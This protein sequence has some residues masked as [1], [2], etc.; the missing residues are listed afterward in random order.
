MVNKLIIR[1]DRP[2]G[3]IN[4][5]LLAKGQSP[6][7]FLIL[8]TGN[9]CNTKRRKIMATKVE[10]VLL[11]GEK[12]F[13]IDKKQKKFHTEFGMFDLEKIKKYGQV[14]KT[15]TGKKFY[16]VEPTIIDLMKK[17]RRMPQI[18]TQKD[19]AQI[20]AVTGLT[21]GWKCLDFGGGSG[22]LAMFIGNLVKPGGTVITYEK[23]PEYAKNIVKNINFC[24][25]QKIVA[26]KNTDAKKFTEKNLDLI[27]MDVIDAEK[28]VKKCFNALKPGGWICVY[29]PH[30]EQQKKAVKEMEK[31]FTHI[32]TIE[33]IQRNWQVSEY[34]HPIPS[35]LVHT[36]FMTF[37][38]KVIK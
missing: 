2:D 20:A 4:D 32:R 38:R 26:V 7:N 13:L 24:G 12:T 30:I 22:F 17:S 23:K 14:I 36:G 21:T 35:Q 11:L 15:N 3:K 5:T 8:K 9:F 6:A 16:A 31:Y 25:L 37:G 27:T 18:V 29:S 10:K 34:T 1:E 19:A 33:T 28:Y